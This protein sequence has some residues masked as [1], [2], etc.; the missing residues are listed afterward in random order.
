MSSRNIRIKELFQEMYN[1][2]KQLLIPEAVSWIEAGIVKDI[3]PENVADYLIIVNEG[4]TYFDKL[5][6]DPEGF[7]RRAKFLKETVIKTLTT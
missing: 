3:E 7:K 5:M 2:F 6:S 1:K 4:L